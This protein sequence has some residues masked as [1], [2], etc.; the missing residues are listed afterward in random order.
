MIRTFLLFI[1]LSGISVSFKAQTKSFLYQG[2]VDSKM[3]VTL[4]LQEEENGCGADPFYNG[5][6]RYDQISNWLQLS[7][8][9]NGKNQ[10]A[11]VEYGFT[12]L[13]ILR[14]EGN[15]MKGI[16]ISPDG[17]RQ[18]PVILQEQKI[19]PKQIESY[20]DMLEK[21]NYENNDC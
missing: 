14:K 7:I 2:T 17:K 18:L 11:M 16:W 15:L 4:Y 6:Y 20:K 1:A 19:G 21:I 8:S 5:I 10:Y 3:P 9:G 13:M 12:G